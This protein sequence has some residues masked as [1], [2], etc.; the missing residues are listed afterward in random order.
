[1][2]KAVIFDFGGVIMRTRD[3]A[4]RRKWEERLG[5]GEFGADQLVFGTSD[6][7]DAGLGVI[8]EEELWKRI[9]EARG[10][11]AATLAEFRAD[12]WSGDRVDRDVV[13]LIER[14]RPRYKVGLLSNAW[15][16][17]RKV[18]ARRE[19]GPLLPLFDAVVVSAE[20]GLQKPDVRIYRRAVDVLGV[21]PPE[22]VFVDDVQANVEGARAAGLAGIRFTEAPDVAAALEALGVRL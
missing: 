1:M 8:T 19:Y 16:S 9:G 6:R 17:L 4:G 12:F 11:D 14:L 3:Y 2:I 5:L 15:D 22:A 7:L 20:E 13:A 18:L 10:F 21:A